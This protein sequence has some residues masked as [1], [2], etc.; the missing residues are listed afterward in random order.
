M[1][2]DIVNRQMFG[3]IFKK[4]SMSIAHTKTMEIISPNETYWGLIFLRIWHNISKS[5]TV[6]INFKV[7]LMIKILHFFWKQLRKIWIFIMSEMEHIHS[8]SLDIS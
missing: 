7:F 8:N 5:V 4:T 2:K 1:E 3:Y 6:N